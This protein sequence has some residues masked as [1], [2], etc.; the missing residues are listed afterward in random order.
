MS[1]DAKYLEND[2][3]KSETTIVRMTKNP[4][5]EEP[6]QV[7]PLERAHLLIPNEGTPPLYGGAL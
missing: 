6:I 4:M 2:I 1:F 5:T 3:T 7:E